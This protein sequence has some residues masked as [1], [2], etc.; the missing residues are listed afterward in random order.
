MRRT[1]GFSLIELILA[2]S[3]VAVLTV[4]AGV[5][6][7]GDILSL[8]AGAGQLLQDIRYTQALSMSRGGGYGIVRLGGNFYEIRKPDGTPFEPE[9]IR[10]KSLSISLF[11][12][13]FNGRGAP[14]NVAD[15]DINLSQGEE[16]IT[17]RV[18]GQ[19]GTVQRL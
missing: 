7:R 15:A 3:I 16:T 18:T 5:R 19:T 13:Q 10:L 9:P 17:L 8:D 2:L 11:N 14:I 1:S 6:W 12:I 4:V